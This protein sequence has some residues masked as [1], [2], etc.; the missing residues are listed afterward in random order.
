MTVTATRVERPHGYGRVLLTASGQVERIVE[1]A[2][3]TDEERAV[4]LINAVALP[5]RR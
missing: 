4:D 1:E 5:I 2:D 3:A